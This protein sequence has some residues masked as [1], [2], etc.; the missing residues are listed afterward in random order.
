M[1]TFVDA[2]L[3][4]TDLEPVDPERLYDSFLYEYDV[5]SKKKFF[6][7]PAKTFIQDGIPMPG[8]YFKYERLINI[9]GGEC[10]FTE[11]DLTAYDFRTDRINLVDNYGQLF[12]E[13]KLKVTIVAGYFFSSVPYRRIRIVDFIKKKAIEGHQFEIFTQDPSAPDEF[14]KGENADFYKKSVKITVVLNRINI[15]YIV[16]ENMEAP[17]DTDYFIDF[18]HT[19]LDTFRLT[20]H[21][22]HSEILESFNVEPEKLREFLENLR[23]GC[24]TLKPVIRLKKRIRDRVIKYMPN[25]GYHYAI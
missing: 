15:H 16:L 7:Y 24:I 4:E 25:F 9:F 2:S 17:E 14:Y 6:F 21:L 18:P 11:S 13:K 12:N 22:K 19:E 20:F 8:Q 10:N 23:K 3:P 1:S 5:I